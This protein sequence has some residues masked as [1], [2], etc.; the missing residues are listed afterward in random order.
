MVQYEYGGKW[1]CG[2]EGMGKERR[3]EGERGRKKKE[4]RGRG[5]GDCGLW[6]VGRYV[7][8]SRSGQ[9]IGGYVDEALD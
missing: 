8:C 4:E 5:K 2:V 7:T 3:R 6:T 9:D 1:V